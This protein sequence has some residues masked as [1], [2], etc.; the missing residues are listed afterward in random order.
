V[1][2]TFNL[3]KHTREK[4]WA[5]VGGASALGFISG[6]L[7]FRRV[8]AAP[9][10]G[11][12]APQGAAGMPAA[13]PAAAP[14]RPV[15]LPGWLDEIVDRLA[16]KITQEVRRIGELAV[17]TASSSLQKT[18]ETSLPRLFT[19]AE[20]DPARSEHAANGFHDIPSHM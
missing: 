12:V 7:L 1:N 4:P 16:T 17:D 20:H 11:Y 13:A 14:S 15:K 10:K 3:T 5:M 6:M 8:Y 9:P 18:V 19:P 2:T